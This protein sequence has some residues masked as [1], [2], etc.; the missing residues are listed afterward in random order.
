[1]DGRNLLGAHARDRVFTE[2]Q[3]HHPPDIPTWASLLT[4]ELQYVEYYDEVTGDVTFREYYDRIADPWHLR[5]LLATGESGRAGAPSSDL[6]AGLRLQ[7]ARDRECIGTSGA[8]A[9]P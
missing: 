1:M 8:F 4:P 9:C 7:L 3:V 2:Y 6:L 5:N